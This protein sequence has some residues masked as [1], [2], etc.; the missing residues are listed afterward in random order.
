[1]SRTD[2]AELTGFGEATLNRWERGAVIQN[3]ANDRYLRL[4][5][6]PDILDRLRKTEPRRAAAQSEATPDS[7]E[8]WRKLQVTDTLLNHQAAFGLL[9]N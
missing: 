2:F 7:G 9:V 4:L 5:E 3:R 8:P 1:M 6:S